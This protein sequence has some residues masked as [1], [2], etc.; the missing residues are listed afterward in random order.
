MSSFIT[1]NKPE[2]DELE[3]LVERGRRS[4]RSLSPRELSRLDVLYRRTTIHLARATTRTTDRQLVGYLN[5]LTARAHSLIYLPP[6]RSMFS[7][8]F[9]FL[10]EGFA[11]C[12]ARHWRPRT[13]SRKRAESAGHRCAGRRRAVRRLGDAPSRTIRRWGERSPRTRVRAR[14]FL[15]SAPRALR[16][17]VR[18]A[19]AAKADWRRAGRLDLHPREKSS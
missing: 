12:I 14:S 3:R 9:L 7:G 17:A 6:R 2:W 13:R 8:A 15:R 4:M 18:R 19:R 5:D 10:I 1:R 16:P 11:R